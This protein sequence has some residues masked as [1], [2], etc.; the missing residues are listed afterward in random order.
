MPRLTKLDRSIKGKVA[1]VTGAASGMGRETAKLF[2]DE[3]ARVAVSD[4][5]QEKVDA[6]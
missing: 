6:V 2:A 3:G 4:L 5:V 1:L